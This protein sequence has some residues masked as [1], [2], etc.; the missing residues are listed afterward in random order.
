MRSQPA[1]PQNMRMAV[2]GTADAPLADNNVSET[3]TS[4]IVRVQQERSAA[5]PTDIDFLP[6][7]QSHTQRV[8]YDAKDAVGNGGDPFLADFDSPTQNSGVVHP[9]YSP[10]VDPQPLFEDT[11]FNQSPEVGPIPN[12]TPFAAPLSEQPYATDPQSTDQPQQLSPIQDT[13]GIFT[14]LP[15]DGDQLGMFDIDLQ[16]TVYI[17]PVPGMWVSPGFQTHFLNGP[18]RTDLPEQFY[19][20]RVEVGWMKQ[21]DPRFALQL[22][23]APGIYSDFDNTGS[24]AW[25]ILGK[26]VGFFTLSPQT[27]GLLGFAYLDRDNLAVLPIVGVIHN[28]SENVRLEFV[29][30]RPKFAYRLSDAP[31][32]FG[33]PNVIQQRWVYLLGEFGGGSWAIQRAGGANDVVTYSDWRLILGIES[34]S[35]GALDWLL[36]VG[37]VFNRDVEYSSGVG[38]YEPDGTGMIRCGLIY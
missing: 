2:S 34:K 33:S 32:P 28:P 5:A 12:P 11:T 3:G 8:A 20:A 4:G 35:Q 25:R 30:P 38:D 10:S 21:F 29:F 27:Q 22:A 18:T 9:V 36:E 31:A 16:T 6:P 13:K 17:P 1:Q 7:V 37:Y 26:A 19:N 24:D 15:G 23:V 14:W